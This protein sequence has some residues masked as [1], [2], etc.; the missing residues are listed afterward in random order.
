MLTQ[1]P[2]F[3]GGKFDWRILFHNQYVR[4]RCLAGE[5]NWVL[6]VFRRGDGL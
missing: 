1:M 6:F 2:I 3:E 5:G 4:C